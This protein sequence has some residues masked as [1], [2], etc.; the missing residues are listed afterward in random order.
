MKTPTGDLAQLGS[1]D[2]GI[3]ISLD[4]NPHDVARLSEIGFRRGVE[5]TLVR[6]GSTAIVR[7]HHQSLCV[8]FTPDLS[9]QV[10]P[11]PSA[12]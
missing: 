2:R 12:S 1:G 5:F 9:V 6:S 10:Q 11:L 4:G 3:V 8:R 7:I